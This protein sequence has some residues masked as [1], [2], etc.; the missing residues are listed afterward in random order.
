MFG[1]LLACI[2]SVLNVLTDVSR[3]KVLDRSFDAGLV[4]V[5][6]KGISCVVFAGVLG[7]LRLGWGTRP[8]L[9]DIGRGLG[10]SPG[11][12]FLLYVSLNAVLEGGAILLYLRALQVSPISYCV[13]FLA[14][15]PLFLLPTGIMFL[16]ET[17]SGGMVTG[18]CLVV[19]G[20]LVMNRQL[21]ARGP[22]EPAR[23]IVRERGSRY[24]LIVAF[25]LTFTNALD[26]WF[27]ISG[28]GTVTFDVKLARSVTLAL[29]KCAM[30]SVFF[31]GLTAIR[32]GDRNTRREKP[33]GVWRLAASVSWTG[34]ARTAGMW[35]MLAGVLDA[36]VLVLQLTA[37]QF[38]VAAVAICIKRAGLILAVILGWFVFKERGITDRVIASLVM[39]AG[40]L[41][42]FLTNPDTAGRPI[43]DTGGA[44][45]VAGLALAAMSG[46]LYLTRNRNA[47]P[48][49]AVTPV[50]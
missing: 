30:L 44:L 5:W 6:C 38:I 39:T 36:M 18:V 22:L 23:A 24:M 15:T 11:P 28:A 26:K 43:L 50:V 33:P 34:V 29:G 4:T 19:V 13:P 48:Q 12:A 16:H 7:V 3:K 8:E 10:L 27:L 31:A 17:V 9:P 25:L 32:M 21:F 49:G 41:I 45:G 46:A 37:M 1:L 20:A 42:F 2:D 40:V 47:L 35:L 14:F